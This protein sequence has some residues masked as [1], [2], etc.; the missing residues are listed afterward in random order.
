MW[1][2]ETKDL[3]FQYLIHCT[4][5]FPK[6]LNKTDG[7]IDLSHFSIMCN[8]SF[9]NDR[10]YFK[11][12]LKL[13]RLPDIHRGA[14]RSLCGESRAAAM[15]TKDV[16][17]QLLWHKR[18]GLSS[19]RFC[20]TRDVLVKSSWPFRKH[21]WREHWHIDLPLNGRLSHASRSHRQVRIWHFVMNGL[22]VSRRVECPGFLVL[23]IKMIQSRNNSG[24]FNLYL[25]SG[26]YHFHHTLKIISILIK[27][28]KCVEALFRHFP[29]F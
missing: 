8:Y 28:K 23:K 21:C 29:V 11:A 27:N 20:I 16:S 19:S 12:V 13:P 9:S 7:R 25:I 2:R 17:L 1:N 14:G 26:D 3:A 6:L 18:A 4:C 24:F 10:G 22:Q 5:G 15:R